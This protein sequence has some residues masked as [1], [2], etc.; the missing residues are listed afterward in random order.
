M[1]FYMEDNPEVP[2]NHYLFGRANR[3]KAE[4]SAKKLG[5]FKDQCDFLEANEVERFSAMNTKYPSV[6]RI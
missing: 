6:S 4:G 2:D 5:E 3:N 1:L